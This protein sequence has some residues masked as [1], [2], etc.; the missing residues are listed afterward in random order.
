MTGLMPISLIVNGERVSASVLPRLNLADFLREHLSLT[1]THVG[2]EHGVCGACTVRVNGDIVRACLLL[3]VQVEN[4]SVE[5]I[6]G[7]SDS[8]E[9]S[10]LQAAFQ[11]RN[12]L[13]CGYCTPG[14]LMAAQDILKHE[15]QA[16]REQ[17]REHLSGNY[18]RCTGYHA[19]VDA[20]EATARARAGR[21]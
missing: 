20:V 15:P 19:I 2:C 4:A 18:C 9:I 11:D 16:D 14:M 7:L 3:A 17:I 21:V 6:E 12:A 13:Q 1:G 10:D 5:T 8:G